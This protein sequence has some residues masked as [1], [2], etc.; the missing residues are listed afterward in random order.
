MKSGTVYEQAL[1]KH[2]WA[3]KHIVKLKVA[4][5]EFWKLDPCAIGKKTNPKT[6]DVTCYAANVPVLSRWTFR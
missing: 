2:Q 5:A 3:E 4:I 6:G 1:A